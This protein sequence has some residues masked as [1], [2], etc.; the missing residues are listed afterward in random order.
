MR[1]VAMAACIGLSAMFLA[2]GIAHSQLSY[3]QWYPAEAMVNA[4]VHPTCI[5]IQLDCPE[6]WLWV[7]TGGMVT[8]A[9]GSTGFRAPRWPTGDEYFCCASSGRWRYIMSGG[10]VFDIQIGCS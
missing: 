3:S 8:C 5:I 9:A 4:G 2:T 1:R 7:P 6:R 10:M